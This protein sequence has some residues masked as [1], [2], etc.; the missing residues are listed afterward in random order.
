MAVDA[1]EAPAPAEAAVTPVRDIFDRALKSSSATRAD[2]ARVEK[3][4]PVPE[5]TVTS[6]TTQEVIPEKEPEQP[7]EVTESQEETAP[8]V[9][10]QEPEESPVGMD[11]KGRYKWGQLKKDVK[12]KTAK[13]KELEQ[14]LQELGESGE[15]LK[16]REAELHSLQ[17]QV[18]EANRE[19]F[20]HRVEATPEWKNTVKDPLEKVF[21]GVDS[22]AQLGKIEG[23]KLYHAVSQIA[24]AGDYAPLRALLEGL[25]PDVAVDIRADA[26]D[27]AKNMLAIQ[28]RAQELKGQSKE[29]YETS[30]RNQQELTQRQQQER[31]AAYQKAAG[32]IGE[33]F[34]ERLSSLLPEDMQ[35]KLD[36]AAIGLDAQG[37]DS[38][39]TETKIYSAFAASA[40]LPLLEA[41]E[42]QGKELKAAREQLA[43]LR[44]NA[45]K[46]NSGVAPSAPDAVQQRS[47][48]DLAKMRPKDFARESM[49]RL[50]TGR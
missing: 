22:L 46:A 5:P 39:D 6:D 14:K 24:T 38:W 25:D 11:E 26:R 34:K 40:V 42:S 1:P 43:K 8:E 12:L 44:G 23:E 45:P 29:A 19:L 37:I 35:S 3:S 2:Y 7:P 16:Q 47:H 31:T 18:E 36:Y 50:T 49:I 30:M 10:P 17:K 41:V 4:D 28:K 27:L 48:A 13:V 33:K 21:E 9:E 32:S 15:R 20:V